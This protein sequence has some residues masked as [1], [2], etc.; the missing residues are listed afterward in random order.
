MGPLA[1]RLMDPARSGVYRAPSLAAVR[2]AC[3]EVPSLRCVRIDLVGVATREALFDR[4]AQALAFPDWF[5][6][7][8]DALEDCLGDLSWTGGEGH[9]LC[10]EDGA[11]LPED[12]RAVFLDILHAAAQSWAERRH[13]FVAVFP[14]GPGP[15]AGL[16]E[17]HR[18][19]G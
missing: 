4:V 7:N 3:G 12:D 16:P 15:G 18:A 11:S 1:Q 14:A 8:W 13:P 6:R 19:P 2:E 9:V 5:G 10:F 17:L